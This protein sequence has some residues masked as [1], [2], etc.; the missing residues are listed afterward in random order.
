MN[1]GN[2]AQDFYLF[3]DSTEKKEYEIKVGYNTLKLQIDSSNN[4]AT[5]GITVYGKTDNEQRYEKLMGFLDSEFKLKSSID[6]L[7]IFSYD[8]LGYKKV[9]I[10]VDN[11]DSPISCHVVE[12]KE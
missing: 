10:V 5:I 2:I 7:G 8:V 9:K 11:T 12:T 1:I 6:M 3:K 4:S